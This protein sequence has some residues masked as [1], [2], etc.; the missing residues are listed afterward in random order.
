M[1]TGCG[2]SHVDSE[3][4]E[5]PVI[6][7]TYPQQAMLLR[8]LAGDDF[9]IITLLPPGS[10]PETYEPSMSTMKALSKADILFT[11]GT[12]G[13]EKAV[14][15]GVKTNFPNLE[16]I[17]SSVGIERLTH[18]HDGDHSHHHDHGDGKDDNGC[19]GEENGDPHLLT[20]I[21]NARVMASNM[22]NGLGK[23]YPE[24]N[25]KYSLRLA[26]LDSTLKVADDS[27][28]SI[29]SVGAAPFV[30][31]HPSLSYFA[32]DYGLTQL[33]LEEEG[34]EPSPRQYAETMKRI[35]TAKPRVVVF[36]RTHSSPQIEAMAKSMSIPTLTV[37]LNS[38]E[39]I[40]NL[41]LIANAI[42]NQSSPRP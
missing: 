40:E 25:G 10:D 4:E 17:D 1:A 33:S 35:S 14:E 38:E 39:W 31:M 11:M 15:R 19:H 34:K 18:T 28:R 37:D 22:A 20:S 13:F 9:E 3:T 29:L 7:V 32:H 26:H 42:K 30:V 23:K 41:Y 24:M 8:D 36:E 27:L 5:R 16:V 2:R 6:A 21:L 12:P